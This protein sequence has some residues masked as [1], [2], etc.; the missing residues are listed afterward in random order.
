M[1][2]A[3]LTVEKLMHMFEVM[4]ELEALC[5]RL[6]ARRMTA[7]ER[8]ELEAEHLAT[9]ELAR[10]GDFERY[11]AA[12]RAFHRSVYLGSGNPMLVETA[13]DFRRRINPFR[14]AQFHVERPHRPQ[15]R[16]ARRHRRGDP[17]PATR[18]RPTGG[19]ASTS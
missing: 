2:V 1:V 3:A 6:A 17:A 14:R 9:A 8:E 11:E 16:G 5:A 19:C 12:N 7:I 15:L 4:A 10:T 13:D 18:R